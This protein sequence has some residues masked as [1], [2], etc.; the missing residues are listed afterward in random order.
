[1]FNFLRLIRIFYYIFQARRLNENLSKI[2][3]ISTPDLL[4]RKASVISAKIVEK[5]IKFIKLSSDSQIGFLVHFY[6]I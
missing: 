6:N 3:G 2:T 1:M 5:I 4:S